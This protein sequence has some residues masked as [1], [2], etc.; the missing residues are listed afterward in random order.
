MKQFQEMKTNDEMYQTKL[1]HMSFSAVFT[2]MKMKKA[3]EAASLRDAQQVEKV[4]TALNVTL[5]KEALIAHVHK[6]LNATRAK[7]AHH[8]I[9]AA[10]SLEDCEAI[11]ARHGISMPKTWDETLAKEAKK[12]RGASSTEAVGKFLQDSTEYAATTGFHGR[13]NKKQSSNYYYGE[14][15]VLA[16]AERQRAIDRER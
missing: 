9:L 4:H 16:E 13:C 1:F 15:G 11:A 7:E 14:N 10:K 6:A 12:R 5:A 2:D 3:K 8:E